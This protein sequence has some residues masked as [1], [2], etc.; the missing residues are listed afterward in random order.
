EGGT[1]MGEAAV[2]DR[3]ALAD[4]GLDGLG[5]VPD[6][7]VHACD[8]AVADKPEGD[9]LPAR[10]IAAHDDPVPGAGVARVLHAD[11]VLVGEEVRQAVV[12]LGSAEHVAGRDWSLVQCV[13]PVLDADSLPVEG[14]VRRGDVAGGEHARHAG[15]KVLVD[16]D[17][18]VDV[19]PGLRGEPRSGSDADA[20]DDGVA[21]DRAPVGG[22][23][24]FDRRVSLEALDSGAK[25]HAYPVVA[26]D[27]AVD[28]SD[29]A[30]QDPLERYGSRLDDRDV[31]SPLP[32][33]G[34]DF[35]A[36]PARADDN[37]AAAA[38]QAL[39]QDIG[40]LDAA[41]IQHAVERAARD[42]QMARL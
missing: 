26:A 3:H 37:H 31:E 38:V 19:E 34:G 14:V 10:G 4:E 32:G 25:Q 29:R 2:V 39:A 30:A 36:D 33:G 40:V 23:D 7:D 6:V 11:V 22:A 16:D 27:V 1:G 24:A 17:P 20:D 5:D 28:G 21:L 9:E 12:D 8:H 15:L 18:V 13:R 35:G 41:Q 42:R